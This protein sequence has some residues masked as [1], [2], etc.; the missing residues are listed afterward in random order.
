M[1]DTLV[2][3]KEW[4]DAMSGLP[5]EVRLEVYEAIIEYGTSG[6][7]PSGLKQMAMLAFNFAKTALDRDREKYEDMKKK[8]S[9]AGKKHKGNQYKNGTSV[10]FDEQM[11]QNGT[12]GTVYVDDYDSVYVNK[13]S[14]ESVIKCAPAPTHD[15]VV[16]TNDKHLEK[17]FNNSSAQMESLLM[18]LGMKPSDAASLK[19]IAKEIVNEWN[20]TEQAHNDYNDFSRHLISTIKIKVQKDKSAGTAVSK[21]EELKRVAIM[22][23]EENYERNRRYEEMR[24]NA[25]SYAEARKSP[26]YLRALNEAR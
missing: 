12:N 4:K 11:E 21:S 24:R 18:G 17:F 1:K 5:N 16:K 26:E 20:I 14:D 3:R 8:R 10:P 2:F 22:R 6:T 19:T 13:L 7:L 9:E 25:V 23:D 15:E